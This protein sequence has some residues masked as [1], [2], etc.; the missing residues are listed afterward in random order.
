MWLERIRPVRYKYSLFQVPPDPPCG[1]N[2]D[3]GCILASRFQS[4]TSVTQT[5]LIRVPGHVS[6]HNQPTKSFT[7][8]SIQGKAHSR[9][10]PAGYPTNGRIALDRS[11]RNEQ[12]SFIR[13]NMLRVVARFGRPPRRLAPLLYSTWHHLAPEHSSK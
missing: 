9:R 7:K 5:G 2:L 4:Q 13:S 1:W 12:F 10:T 8:A 6:R 11:V 3:L